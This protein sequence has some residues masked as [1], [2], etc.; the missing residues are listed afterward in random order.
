MISGSA[1]ACSVLLA[2]IDGHLMPNRSAIDTGD[3]Y[4]TESLSSDQTVGID[5]EVGAL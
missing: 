1:V 2:G 3:P 5:F 4:V